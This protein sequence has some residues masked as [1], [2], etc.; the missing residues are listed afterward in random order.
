MITDGATK[1]CSY[2]FCVSLMIHTFP[3]L[4]STLLQNTLWPIMNANKKHGLRPILELNALTDREEIATATLNNCDR[5]ASRFIENI[6]ED[7]IKKIL[8]CEY[9]CM[10]TSS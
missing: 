9:L 6:M 2:K 5:Q 3:G 7:R 4:L 8:S 10:L 1:E